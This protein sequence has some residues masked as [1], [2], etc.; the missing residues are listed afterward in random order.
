MN[1][2]IYPGTF[3]PITFG[4]VDVVKRAAKLFGKVTVAISNNPRKKPTFSV[5]KR[6]ALAKDALSDV[7]GVEVESFTGLLVEYA[8]KKKASAVVRG[9]RELSDFEFEFQ[10]A[11]VNRKLGNLETVLIVTDPKYFYLSSSMVKEIAEM[12]GNVSCF[13]PKKVELS[14]KKALK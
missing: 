10:T 4:H 12:G 6:I 7:K 1:R 11:I 9:L 2:V 13:V 3:D 5:A 14:L 8:K